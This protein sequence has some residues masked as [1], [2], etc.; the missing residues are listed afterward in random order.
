M[1]MTTTM[2]NM[3]NLAEGYGWRSIGCCESPPWD[4]D[5]VPS[6]VLVP[7]SAFNDDGMLDDDWGEGE[8]ELYIESTGDWT[9]WAQGTAVASGDGIVDLAAYLESIGP[10]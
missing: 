3:F 1:T 8:M 5:E 10:V 2:S 9:H 7:P 6:V 4:D